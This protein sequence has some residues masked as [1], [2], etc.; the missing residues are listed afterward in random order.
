MR[1]IWWSVAL[2]LSATLASNVERLD[3]DH[4]PLA[5]DF[6]KAAGR[7]RLVALLSPT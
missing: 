3:P 5:Q 7:A 1:G 4:Q 2:L 6:Q